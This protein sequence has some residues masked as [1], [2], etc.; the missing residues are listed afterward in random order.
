MKKEEEKKKKGEVADTQ[1]LHSGAR[2]E[3]DLEWFKGGHTKCSLDMQWDI[4]LPKEK[5]FVVFLLQ[6]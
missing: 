5:K 6:L 2:Q 1:W 4:F 3:S